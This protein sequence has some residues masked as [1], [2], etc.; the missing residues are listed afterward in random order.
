MKEQ[1]SERAVINESINGTICST[2]RARYIDRR[3]Y[4]EWAVVS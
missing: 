2:K 1:K 4:R 3:A